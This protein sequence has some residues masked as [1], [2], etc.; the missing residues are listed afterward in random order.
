MRFRLLL[1]AGVCH[2]AV[3][4]QEPA[5]AFPLPGWQGVP[6]KNLILNPGFELGGDGWIYEYSWAKKADQ[7]RTTRDAKPAEILEQVGAD[8]GRC[9]RIPAGDGT[10]LR[11]Y[12]FPIEA[13][14]RYSLTVQ[15]RALPGSA[16]GD[17]TVMSFDPEWKGAL[18]TKV[19]DVPGDRWQRYTFGITYQPNAQMK[20][21]IRFASSS[22]VLVDTVQLETGP[23]T[24]YEAPV[25]LAVV[26][27]GKPYVVRGR[28]AAGLRIRVVPGTQAG[29]AIQVSAVARDAWGREAWKQEFSA[30]GDHPSEVA[31]TAPQERLGN[32]HVDLTARRGGAVIGIGMSRY[33]I[34]DPTV[35]ETVP[36]GRLGSF[37]VCYELFNYPPWLNREAGTYLSDL[38]VRTT[39]FFA[40]LPDDL[41]QPPADDIMAGLRAACATMRESGIAVLPC[42]DLFPT[43]TEAGETTAMPEPALIGRY[44]ERLTAWIQA[45]RSEVRAVEIFNEPNLWRVQQG[46]ERGKPTVYPRKYVQFQQAA[47]ETIKGID[48]DI[49]VVANALNGM[50]WEWAQE[51]M[52]LGGAKWMDVFS[53]HP[54]RSHP[55]EPSTNADIRRMAGILKD[56]GFRGPLFNSEFYFAANTF[57][58]R[59]GIEETRRGYYVP[60]PEELRAAGRT[61]R[62]FI[63]N[64]AAGVPACPFAPGITLFQF[65]PGNSLFL[66]DLFPAY[67]ATSR[68]LAN[69]G[70]GEQL[71][72]G[73]AFVAF[74]FPASAGGPLAAVWTAQ[75]GVVGR[76][77]LHGR[78]TAYD[79][80]GN[81][82]GQD[83]LAAGIRLATDPTWLKFPVGTDVANLR[84]ALATA[85]VHGLGVPFAITVVP[86]GPSGVAAR[87]ASRSNR[88]IDG[89]VQVQSV[90]QGWSLPGKA[91]TFTALPAGG[92]IDLPLPVGGVALNDLGSY[93]LGLQATA[94]GETVQTTTTVRPLFARH[95]PAVAA[96]GDL[97]E[98]TAARWITLSA[99]Q[100]SKVFNGKWPRTGDADISARL[101]LGWTDNSLALAVVVT[102]DVHHPADAERMG[103]Q[104]DALQIFIDQLG[105]AGAGATRTGDDVAYTI[106]QMGGRNTTWLDKGS[107]GNF[108]GPNNSN[109]GFVDS[110]P[111]VA[112]VRAGTTTTYE[113]VFPRASCLPKV[114]LAAGA[115]FG[116]SV[117]VN[118]N[119]G[120]GRKTGVTTSPAGTEPYGAPK[121]WPSVVLIP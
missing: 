16:K 38:G 18:Y 89:T 70:P 8:G 42:I 21:Y 114:P 48:P 63:H 104:G 66:W 40:R 13:G 6:G 111:Q 110:D 65:Q 15:L 80:M 91:Q 50:R 31:V 108:K 62:E 49:I 52:Q 51:W 44:R 100:A 75:P 41:G 14:K 86:T 121:D 82:L 22:G 53:F 76:M 26:R 69:C 20:A 96:D 9:L 47:Y 120:P 23:A 77:T 27:D 7:F 29:E 67:N 95:L 93:P 112:I 115:C 19:S 58:E 116:F 11:S 90:P 109:E 99:A 117:L 12:C 103:W 30:P 64:I 28:D 113:I 45:L 17:C 32:F 46:P 84:T 4:A 57:Q 1:L 78:F 5:A 83:D 87:I 94:G 81:P 43:T 71:D 24:A 56:G 10:T 39:R 85:E 105:D 59:A 73:S 101:A 102:D 36:A 3:A 33:A 54:Y 37:G 55:D 72:T 74:L 88:P 61:V 119:D 92:T 98:W 107:E 79:L 97:G 34:L 35:R 25:G 118:D 60:H 106:G 2:V 68:L